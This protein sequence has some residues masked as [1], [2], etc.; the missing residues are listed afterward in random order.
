MYNGEVQ[1][2]IQ[3]HY[4]CAAPE[5]EGKKQSLTW[6][7]NFFRAEKK[8]K[9]GALNILNILGM[10]FRTHSTIHSIKKHTHGMKYTIAALLEKQSSYL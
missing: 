9:Y 10:Q 8:I 6:D 5:I 3:L 2:S 1:F 7:A 4:G